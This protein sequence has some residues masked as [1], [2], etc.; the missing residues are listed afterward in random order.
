M[1]PSLPSG[2]SPSIYVPGKVRSKQNPLYDT[3]VVTA[4]NPI[5]GS[6]GI[7]SMFQQARNVVNS[8]WPNGV[9]PYITNMYKAGELQGGTSFIVGALRLVTIG[10]AETDVVQ[11]MRN[12]DIQLQAGAGQVAYCDAPPEYWPGAAGPF[13]PGTGTASLNGFPDARAVNPFDV[14]PILL[15]DGLNFRLVLQGLAFN[16]SQDFWLRVYLDGQTTEPAQ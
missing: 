6:Q 8:Q 2:A 11:F 12:F 10:C 4:G 7:V 13:T 3:Y 16:A 14:D 5:G 9:P 15:T 1:T